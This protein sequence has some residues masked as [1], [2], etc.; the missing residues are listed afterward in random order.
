MTYN[1]N[2]QYWEVGNEVY[3]NWEVDNHSPAHDP[4]TYANTFVQY[5]QYARSDISFTRAEQ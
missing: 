3:G 5:Y 1:Y 2:F 4:V